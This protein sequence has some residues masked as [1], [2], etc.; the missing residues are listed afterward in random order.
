MLLHV[1]AWLALLPLLGPIGA[2]AL[3]ALAGLL[4]LLMRGRDPAAEA[5]ERA[6]DTALAALGPTLASP[7]RLAGLAAELAQGLRRR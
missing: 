6:R 3:L 4:I 1:A 2:P 5:A 7:F